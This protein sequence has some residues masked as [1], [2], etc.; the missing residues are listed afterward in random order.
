[1]TGSFDPETNLLYWGVGNPSPDWNGDS[2]QGDNLHTC[3]LLALDIATGQLRWHFQF[4]PHDTHDWDS[5]HVPI[6]FDAKIAGVARK[7][8]AVANRNAFYYV[9]DRTTGAFISATAFATQSWN[10][11]FDER[12]RPIMRPGSEPT[13]DGNV[14]SPNYNSGTVWLSPSFS[15]RTRLVYIPARDSSARYFKRDTPYEEGTFFPGGGADLLPFEEHKSAIRALEAESG[16]LRWEY[17]LLTPPWAGVLSTAGDLVFS[18]SDE[19]LF[20]ALDANN[21]SLLWSVQLGGEITA[22]PVS[23][24]IDGRQYVAIA[25][26]RVMYVFGSPESDTAQRAERK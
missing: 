8:V 23:Y 18:G 17:A 3:S 10:S 22:N 14:V 15:P 25:A 21:G 6:L 12:G 5:N 26:G 24:A 11:G 2:R 1:M 7:L 13:V 19:G 16:K 9:L 20:Y 4:T